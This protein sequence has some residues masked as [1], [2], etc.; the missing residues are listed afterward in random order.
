MSTC[1]EIEDPPGPRQYQGDAQYMEKT[2]LCIGDMM[3]Y[4]D[5]TKH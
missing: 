2:M 3:V 5:R 4:D 1:G